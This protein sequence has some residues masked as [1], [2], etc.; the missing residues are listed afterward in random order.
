MMKFTLTTALVSASALTFATLATNNAAFANDSTV[1]LN[2]I[3]VYATKTEQEVAKVPQMVAVV[4][5]QEADARTSSKV[6]DI[7]ESVTGLEFI[8]GPAR[9]GEY[10]VMRGFDSTSIL[11]K[12]DDRRLNFE[13]AHDG[14][15]F[16]DPSLLKKVEVVKGASSAIHGS[17]ALGGV[18]AFETKDA[19]D[20]LKAGETEGATITFGGQTAN[21]EYYSVLTAYQ[22]GDSYDVIGSVT[23]RFSGSY[24]L[25]DG[26]KQRSDDDI[27]TGLAKLSYTLDEDSVVRVAFNSFNGSSTE[28]TNTQAAAN[29]SSGL[30]LVDKDISQQEISL[31]YEYN[32]NEMLDLKTHAYYSITGVEETI[33]EA[34]T[35]TAA[36]DVLDREIQT[37]GFD[38][39]NTSRFSCDLGFNHSLTYGLDFYQDDQTGSD[40]DSDSN[41]GVSGTNRAGVP[42]AKQTVFGVFLQD[43]LTKNIAENTELY[44]S[45]A[46]RYD[47]FESDADDS[48]QPDQTRVRF[49][50]RIGA[51]LVFDDKY[52]VFANYSEGFRAP[53]L[54]ELYAQGTHFIVDFGAPFGSVANSFVANPNLKPETSRTV[55]LGFGMDYESVFQADDKL[56]FKISRYQTRASDYIEQLVSVSP[57]SASNTTTYTNVTRADIWGYEA[58]I[59]YQTKH[60]DTKLG[61]SINKGKND[62]TG[63]HLTSVLPFVANLS[64]AYK[65]ADADNSILGYTAKFVDSL[66]RAYVDTTSDYTRGGYAVHN[67]FYSVQPSEFNKALTIDVGIDNLFDKQ[68]L[69]P[70]TFVHDLERNYKIRATY[71]F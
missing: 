4:D 59:S 26:T 30:N 65:F 51:S 10:P 14:R 19:K 21:R 31:K 64:T 11:I 20:F 16:I 63:V 47:H 5:A 45:P 29:A 27:Y 15:Y 62:N 2:D 35:L 25:N 36:S 7:L 22:R 53:N 6:S 9:N 57:F 69:A 48:S 71:K 34:T 58:D 13:S 23:T 40:T 18:I 67:L 44:I 55:E 49:T 3:T 1:K 42:N 17:G 43:E 8:G 66:D 70:Q 33:L 39:E 46:I 41:S 24:D 56:D 50:P 28:N 52:T 37:I 61:F 54:T 38:A 60:V 12:V 68:Y 32:P